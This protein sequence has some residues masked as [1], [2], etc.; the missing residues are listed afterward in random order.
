MKRFDYWCSSCKRKF[1][2]LI[3][4][5]V[6]VECPMCFTKNVNKLVSAPTIHM[7]T[8]SDSKLRET[9]SEDFY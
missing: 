9:L 3:R 6:T 2:E 5:D 1:E 7:S 4:E 8:I